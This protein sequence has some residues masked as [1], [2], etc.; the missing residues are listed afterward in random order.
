MSESNPSQKNVCAVI[1]TYHPDEEFQARLKLVET[2]FSLVIIVDNGSQSS[3]L[4]ML[5]RLLEPPHVV[6]VE[7]AVNLGVAAALNQ[8]VNLAL[9]KGYQWVVTLDQDTVIHS[10]FLATLIDVYQDSG[11]GENLIGSNYWDV[12][13]KRNFVQC[14]AKR[15]TYL[16]KKTLIT[17]G[18]LLPLS[19]FQ[20]IGF[21]REDYFI[22][23]VDHEFCL[24]AKVHGS[25][26]LISC[27]PIMNHSIGPGV[28]RTNWLRQIL[29]LS[30]APK[31]K[32]FIA[33]NSIVTAKEYFFKDPVWS[34]RQ[35]SQLVAIIL[36]ILIFEKDKIKQL[37]A[38]IFGVI[39]GVIGKM[40][41]IEKT[42]PNGLR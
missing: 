17:S 37:K 42:W 31:R 34:I 19:L 1:I 28:M 13:K 39:H 20:K 15:L 10:D 36:S 18:T 40:G 7:N 32:Y 3:S 16:E 29:S 27:R 33:R 41:P 21:F 6:L 25:R 23:S 5:K 11:G 2:Q 24:R 14:K 30:H 8:G 22:D 35:W 4:K 12:H 26:S 38:I 9:H